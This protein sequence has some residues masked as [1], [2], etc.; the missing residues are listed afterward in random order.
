MTRLTVTECLTFLRWISPPARA[1]NTYQE[2]WDGSHPVHFWWSLLAIWAAAFPVSRLRYV[3]AGG[4]CELQVAP[5][6]S[7]R[8]QRE[9]AEEPLRGWHHLIPMRRRLAHHESGRHALKCVSVWRWTCAWEVILMSLFAP[10]WSPKVPSAHL[11]EGRKVFAAIS[12]RPHASPMTFYWANTTSPA[13][14]GSGLQSNCSFKKKFPVWLPLGLFF[15][16]KEERS[17]HVELVAVF[18]VRPGQMRF[19]SGNV[20]A[21]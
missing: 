11:K 12:V 15:F 13:K 3:H 8:S 10:H 7:Q 6:G 4:V 14:S 20:A 1:D 18:H 5:E 17:Q 21:P 16:L 9:T 2:C 19:T